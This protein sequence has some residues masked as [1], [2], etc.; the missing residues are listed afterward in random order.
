MSVEL[1][2]GLRTPRPYAGCRWCEQAGAPG[3]RQKHIS[4]SISADSDSD[5]LCHPLSTP[6]MMFG[7]FAR[8]HGELGQTP[9]PGLDLEAGWCNPP[10]R[11]KHEV[12]LT[13]ATV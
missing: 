13:A 3:S 7:N 6:S 2:E 10:N 12:L 1:L 5:M 9:C 11:A 4:R 8:L